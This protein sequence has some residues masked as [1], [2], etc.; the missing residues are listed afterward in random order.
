MSGVT[1]KVRVNMLGM[2]I[3]VIGFGLAA[4]YGTI[5]LTSHDPL[6]F[7]S[8]FDAIPSRIVIYHDGQATE[9]RAG[10][11]G[12]DSL[13]SAVRET[14]AQGG[15]RQ[16][17]IGLSE[18]SLADAYHKYVSVEAFFDRTVRL[19][20]WFNT[21]CTQMLFPITG[22]HSDE[23]VVFL[24]EQGHYMSGAPALKTTQPLRNAVAA[25]GYGT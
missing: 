16:S 6:W 12:F 17:G 21:E 1:D 2:A 23:K 24:A 25:L 15:A 11:P 4:V 3:A 20:T 9:Y 22:R 13:A 10:Q 14:L 19:H 5:L 8:G 18:D 7:I